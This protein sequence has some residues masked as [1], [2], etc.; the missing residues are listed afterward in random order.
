MSKN[1]IVSND[2][3]R[4]GV[5]FGH[6]GGTFDRLEAALGSL[7]AHFAPPYGATGGSWDTL[8]ALL[9][10]LRRRWEVLGLTLRRLRVLVGGLGT[11]W[12]HFGY[13]LGIENDMLLN[14]HAG[15][16]KMGSCC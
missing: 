6:P 11:P 2:S 16:Q 13:I 5:T 3:S 12:G 4:Q 8:R 15:E 9:T 1:A 14:S 7:G 10:A